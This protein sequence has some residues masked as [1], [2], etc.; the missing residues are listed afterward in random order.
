MGVLVGVFLFL[1]VIPAM[2]MSN[3]SDYRAQ[4]VKYRATTH[5]LDE[6]CFGKVPR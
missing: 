1:G 4:S 5:C 6:A 2:S 3:V